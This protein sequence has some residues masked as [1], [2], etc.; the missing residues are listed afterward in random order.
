MPDGDRGG[1]DAGMSLPDGWRKTTAADDP[2]LLRVWHALARWTG[3]TSGAELTLK[4]DGSVL[5]TGAVPIELIPYLM[6]EWFVYM[7]ARAP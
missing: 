5:A 4:E 2:E 6:A 7:R 3:P 1:M